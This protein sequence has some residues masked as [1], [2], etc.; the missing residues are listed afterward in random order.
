LTTSHGVSR[1][2]KDGVAIVTA[3]SESF[4]RELVRELARRGYAIVVV[5]LDRQCDAEATVEEVLSGGGT[6]V[7]VRADLDDELDVE[8]LFAES[9]AAFGGVDFVVHTKT[10]GAPVLYEHAARN[11]RR[12]SA[13]FRVGDAE[14][15]SRVL[16]ALDSWRD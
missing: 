12:G 8:R 6:A 3:G 7:A 1:P 13:I 16:A 11:L 9:A 2:A 5:Y 10:D 14:Q 4:G 15:I